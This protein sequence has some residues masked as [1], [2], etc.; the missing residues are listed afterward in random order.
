MPG[1]GYSDYIQSI[2]LHNPNAYISMPQY[3]MIIDDYANNFSFVKEWL[4]KNT[5]VYQW[6]DGVPKIVCFIKLSPTI[7]NDERTFVANGIRAFFTD[8]L[9]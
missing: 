2:E 6:K 1:T 3:K 5:E 9:S 4:R 7:T 8:I